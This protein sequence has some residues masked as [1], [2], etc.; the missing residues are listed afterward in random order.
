MEQDYIDSFDKPAR[1]GLFAASLSPDL[2]ADVEA[3]QAAQRWSS[4][5]ERAEWK[6]DAE[7]T[8]AQLAQAKRDEFLEWVADQTQDMK[9]FLNWRVDL[10]I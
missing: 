1:G 3:V 2:L 7:Q 8:S 6:R 9:D 5:A 10:A 4:D